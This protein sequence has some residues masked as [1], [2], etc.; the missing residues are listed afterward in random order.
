MQVAENV[1]SLPLARPQTE[2]FRL[3]ALQ[4]YQL[5]DSSSATDPDLDFLTALAAQLCGMP[6][7]CL[8]LVEGERVWFKA[9]HGVPTQALARDDSYCA[10]AV[11]DGGITEFSDVLLDYRTAGMPW[12]LDA[13]R[14]RH[15]CAAPLCSPDGYPIGTLAVLSEQPGQLSEA[16]RATLQQLARQVMAVLDRNA[17]QATL[18]SVLHERELLATTDDLTGL[19]NRRSLLQKLKFEVARARRF[20][21]PLSALMLELDP[22][23]TLRAERGHA[24]LEQ[25]LAS[26]GQ[27]LRDNVRVID[28]P[29]RYS[30]TLFCIMLPNTP[31]D[32]AHILAHN[33]RQKIAAQVHALAGSSLPVTASVGIGALDFMAVSEGEALLQQAETSLAQARRLGGDSVAYCAALPDSSAVHG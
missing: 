3:A 27:L 1:T 26:V 14:V 18:A 7:A 5:T 4:R 28:V 29:S 10:L 6:L 22:A 33:L 9:V 8:A 25:V 17:A 21:S 30:E 31:L 20:R 16:Q 15:Y 23:A 13:P 24:V 12:T 19:H 2:Q 11:L 32:G